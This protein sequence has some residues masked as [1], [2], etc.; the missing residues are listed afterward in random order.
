MDEG[1]KPNDFTLATVKTWGAK[2]GVTIILDGQTETNQKP[3]KLLGNPRHIQVDDR[4]LVLKTSGTYVVLGKVQNPDL[5]YHSALLS[6]SATL[7]NVIARV[8]WLHTALDAVGVI[9]LDE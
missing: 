7:A 3:V 6:S 5:W 2:T 4:V 9:G 8:N 1:I